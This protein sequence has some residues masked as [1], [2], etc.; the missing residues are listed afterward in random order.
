MCLE[1]S[2]VNDALVRVQGVYRLHLLRRQH[3]V[4]YLDV[5]LDVGKLSTAWDRDGASRNC[6]V[7]HDLGLA[8]LMPLA[9]FFKP[10]ITPKC[11]VF[12]A[13][14][15]AHRNVGD[16]VDVLGLVEAQQFSLGQRRVHFYL[17]DDRFDA[18][19][20]EQVSQKLQVEV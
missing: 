11:F 9:D 20:A 16:A 2:L 1:G 4:I 15:P 17:V 8:F 7:E 12:D 19:V 14:D 10:L 18:A 5:L 6:P 3:E 13:A